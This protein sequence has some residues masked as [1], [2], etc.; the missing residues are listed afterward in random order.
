MIEHFIDRNKVG[1]LIISYYRSGSHFLHDYIA[2]SLDECSKITEINFLNELESVTHESSPYKV[3]ILHSIHP[4]F[5]LLKKDNLLK[6]W[7]VVHL[8]RNDKVS[9]FIS[10]YFWYLSN[11]QGQ[12]QFM[13]HGTEY[14]TYLE[15]AKNKPINYNIENVKKWL[16]E[17]TL[18][19]FMHNDYIVDYQDLKILE[20]HNI[21][22]EPNNYDNI[23]LQDLFINHAEIKDLLENFVL[24]QEV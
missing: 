10:H 1:T 9:H 5:Y 11:N 17:H 15:F 7:H 4:K 13:H 22:W 21:R 20:S 18:S 3:A 14:S 23:Q 2:D 6:N 16:I 12:T 24:T 19:Y 8:T